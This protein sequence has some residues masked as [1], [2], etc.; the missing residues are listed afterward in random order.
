MK[1]TVLLMLLSLATVPAGAQTVT[2]SVGVADAG[3]AVAQPKGP[4]G[5]SPRADEALADAGVAPDVSL[6]QPTDA[7][8]KKIRVPRLRRG[9]ALPL[10]QAQRP[11][12]KTSSEAA[13]ASRPASASSRATLAPDAPLLQAQPDV[14]PPQLLS[15]ESQQVISEAVEAAT[16]HEPATVFLWLLL[17]AAAL[18]AGRASTILASH[19]TRRG[20]L[21]SLLRGFSWVMQALGLTCVIIVLLTV[22]PGLSGMLPW[23]LLGFGALG[24]WAGRDVLPDV[25]AHVVLRLE[26]RIRPGQRLDSCHAQGRVQSLGLR[27]TQII[28]EAGRVI[29]VPN[30]LIVQTP[31]RSDPALWPTRE[32]QVRL[33]DVGVGTHR[34]LL[35]DAVR[36]SPWV[37]MEAQVSAQ[38]DATDP[39]LWRLRAQI[40]EA[41]YGDRFAGE[42]AEQIEMRMQAELT[43]AEREAEAASPAK[44]SV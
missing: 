9:K 44:T 23:V 31:L 15:P 33:P 38:R 30:H 25:L 32:V 4:A 19:L 11:H 6:T 2:S 20:L 42:I 43:D 17:I 41:R 27:T 13:S 8:L 21:P 14:G 22:V 37:P 35:V 1:P 26:G 28:D 5:A 39:S 18:L 10:P 36:S 34:Q 7:G 12:I 29:H 16:P 40:I 3:P 24:V